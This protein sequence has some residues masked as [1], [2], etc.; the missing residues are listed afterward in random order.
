MG[1]TKKKTMVCKHRIRGKLIEIPGKDG[2]KF[3][4][5]G[6]EMDYAKLERIAHQQAIGEELSFCYLEYLVCCQCN[7]ILEVN[8]VF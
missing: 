6:Y 8:E 4:T 1:K 5:A 2:H 3:G 7:K